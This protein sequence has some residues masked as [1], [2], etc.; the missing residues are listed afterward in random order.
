MIVIGC[1]YV[2]K[3]SAANEPGPPFRMPRM[4]AS[5]RET[6]VGTTPCRPLHAVTHLFQ[7]DVSLISVPFVQ[8]RQEASAMSDVSV[9]VAACGENRALGL[10]CV[11]FGGSPHGSIPTAL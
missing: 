1:L 10:I 11:E 7:D 6:R 3:Y 5:P 9:E 2:F 8:A 4:H